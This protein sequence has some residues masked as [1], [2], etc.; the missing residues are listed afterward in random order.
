M[1]LVVLPSILLVISAVHAFQYS[2]L[3]KYIDMHQ[4][5]YVEVRYALKKKREGELSRIYKGENRD[6]FSLR[7]RR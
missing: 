3:V 6:T 4:E 5:E 2:E 1:N 7:I